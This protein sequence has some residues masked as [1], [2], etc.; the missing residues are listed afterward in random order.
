[1][2]EDQVCRRGAVGGEAVVRVVKGSNLGRVRDLVLGQVADHRASG[3]LGQ[4]GLGLEFP[5]NQAG[6]DDGD[7]GLLGREVGGDGLGVLQGSQ[8]DDGLVGLA[9]GL[10]RSFAPKGVQ[11]GC[12]GDR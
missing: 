2:N 3:H 10:V 12:S 4:R 7:E 5:R 8:V 9:E 11:V 6:E 1:M